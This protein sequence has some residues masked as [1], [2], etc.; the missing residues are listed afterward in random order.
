MINLLSHTSAV[1]D[2]RVAEAARAAAKGARQKQARA[3]KVA[4]QRERAVR[5]QQTPG[6][7]VSW[8][9]WYTLAQ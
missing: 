8:I 3:A 9:L 7:R 1:G 5:T 6:M 2:E 4:T